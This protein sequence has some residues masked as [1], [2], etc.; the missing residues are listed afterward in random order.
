MIKPEPVIDD[1]GAE[2]N[3]RLPMRMNVDMELTRA[4][5]A[6][7]DSMAFDDDLEIPTILRS[8]ASSLI[9]SSSL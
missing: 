6:K 1:A 8:R 3:D 7:D 9:D 4:Q 2:A 5:I